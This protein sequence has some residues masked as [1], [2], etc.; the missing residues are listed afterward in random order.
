M[1]VMDTE[2]LNVMVDEVNRKCG[3]TWTVLTDNGLDFYQKLGESFL[4]SNIGTHVA[5]IDLGKERVTYHE[6]T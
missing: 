5:T 4:P 3:S 1:I 2:E 6:K